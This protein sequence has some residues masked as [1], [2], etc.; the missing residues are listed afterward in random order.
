MADDQLRC[1]V[2]IAALK[3][4]KLPLLRAGAVS[5]AFLLFGSVD[6]EEDSVTDP[7]RLSPG[8]PFVAVVNQWSEINAL[9]EDF[10][11]RRLGPGSVDAVAFIEVLPGSTNKVRAKVGHAQFRPG[12][13]GDAGRPVMV[14]DLSEERIPPVLRY[15]FDE[16]VTPARAEEGM[17]RLQARAVP[18]PEHEDYANIGGAIVNGWVKADHREAAI[19]MMSDELTSVYWSVEL[20]VA[21]FPAIAKEITR[22]ERPDFKKAK[23]NGASYQIVAWAREGE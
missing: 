14:A 21:S 9:V 20:I 17:W 4:E 5:P 3:K 18:L 7:D 2:G 1:A 10:V 16:F 6:G 19:Q 15:C 13:V 22:E 8:M 12:F 11:E 23:R